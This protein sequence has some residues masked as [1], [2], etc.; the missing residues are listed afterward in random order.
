MERGLE[1]KAREPVLEPDEAAVAAEWEA[2]A[3]AQDRREIV[4]VLRAA[5]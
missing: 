1:A 2:R 4:C 5:L 3:P